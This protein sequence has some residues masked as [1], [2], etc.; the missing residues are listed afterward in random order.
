[1]KYVPPANARHAVTFEVRANSLWDAAS[2]GV[3]MAKENLFDGLRVIYRDGHTV[4]FTNKPSD[5]YAVTYLDPNGKRYSVIV[6]AMKDGN[7][8]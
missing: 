1:M 2:D 7:K 3:A 6:E 4:F 8:H 5:R